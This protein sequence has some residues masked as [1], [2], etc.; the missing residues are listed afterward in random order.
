VGRTEPIVLSIS[1][2]AKL[3]GV[4]ESHVRNMIRRGELRA[5][6]FGKR[7]LVPVEAVDAVVDGNR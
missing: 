4:S 1:Q 7:V 3:L 6:K 5:V 2:T